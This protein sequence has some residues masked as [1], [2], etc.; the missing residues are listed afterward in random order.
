[1][2][3]VPWRGRRS[4]RLRGYDYSQPGEYFVT[5]CTQDREVRFGE[6][7][8]EQ[9]RLSHVGEVIEER[10]RAVEAK[11]PTVTLGPYVIMPNHLHAILTLERGVGADPRVRPVSPA[12]GHGADTWVR[13]YRRQE[14]RRFGSS[15]RPYWDMQPA[16]CPGGPARGT[17]VQWFKTMTTNEYIRGVR[18]GTWP[19]FRKRL[20][21]RN[22]WE[23]II[24]NQA[25]L[26]EIET[27]IESNP[28]EW[29]WDEENREAIRHIVRS[30]HSRGPV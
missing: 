27:Y 25:D 5:L 7:V 29:A 21:Q 23:H 10:W 17:I 14:R 12:Y 19:P 18:I 4:I 6:I 13:P 24:R 16:G 11:F 26:A 3:D 28:A 1:M 9:M 8:R 22:Y 30:H 15:V 2:T 20:W